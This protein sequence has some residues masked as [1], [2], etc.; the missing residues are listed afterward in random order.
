MTILS[1][2]LQRK[3]AA[4]KAIVLLLV[5]LC[6]R[7]MR[8]YKVIGRSSN[9]FRSRSLVLEK[10][11]RMCDALFQKHY[12]LHREDFES[13]LTSVQPILARKL[14]AYGEN[15]SPRLL[16]HAALRFL[17]GGSYL[18]IGFGYEL[19]ENM[20]STYAFWVIN[21]I[22]SAVHNIIFPPDEAG[23]RR[24]EE[25]FNQIMP[26]PLRHLQRGC[27]GAGDGVVFRM[28]KPRKVDVAGNV[29]G[30]FT[31]KGYYAWGMQ[32]I[33]DSHC[34]FLS[35]SMRACSSTHD[36]TAYIMSEIS[37]LINDGKLPSW[38]YLVFDEAY[39]NKLQELTPVKGRGLGIYE[40]SF[41]YY[42]SL[43]RQVVERA[44]GI[45]VAR[46]G[47][48]WRPL[49]LSLRK[50]PIVI[51]V[52]CKLHNICVDRFTAKHRIAVH[53]DDSR[54]GGIENRADN[55]AVLY[56][57]GTD[58]NFPGRRTDI[59]RSADNPMNA[60]R[61]KLINELAAHGVQRP[62]HSIMSR[63]IRIQNSL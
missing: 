46:W 5:V 8:S 54:K 15:L 28:I 58:G 48:F 57:D 16:L 59:E 3:E 39:I 27:V 6:I 7:G 29:S 37:H 41:N 20:V 56:T 10:I 11:S 24:V 49:K 43:R 38:A 12:R 30:F 50:I 40:D 51:R 32:A 44:F 2:N 52:C 18:D 21:A 31:R 23:L 63:V 33:V 14:P 4:K 9:L 55:C 42:L 17:A 60:T 26:E 36:S 35:I 22:D 34:R 53:V 45:L 61:L 62:A 19:P 1:S 47:I 25:G 13:I